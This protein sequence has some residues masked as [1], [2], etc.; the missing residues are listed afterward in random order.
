MSPREIYYFMGKCLV[1]DELPHLRQQILDQI[2]K[3]EFSWEQFVQVGSSHLVLPALYIKLRNANLLS[4]LP[5]ELAS[6]LGEIHALNVER[7]KRLLD[8]I[9]CL[10]QLLRQSGI[11]AV[12]LKGSGVLLSGLYNDPGERILSDIDCLVAESD[13]ER[14]VRGVIAEGYTHPPFL[15]EKL[16]LMHHFPSLFKANEAAQIE[17]H[18]IPVGVRQMK[19]LNLETLNSRLWQ[20]EGPDGPR[21]LSGGDQILINLIHSQL[22]DRGQCYAHIPLRTIYEFY[23]LTRNDDLSDLG[24]LH[25]RIKIILNNY[26]AVAQKLFTPSQPFP[27]K[28]RLRSKLFMFR[29]ELNKTSRIYKRFSKLFRSLADLLFAYVYTLTR[30]MIQKEYRTYL[31]IRLSNPAWYRH[32][33]SVVRKRF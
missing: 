28:N 29:F 7:N 3:P 11:R 5:E 16:P 10:D 30:A 15:P 19:Y 4:S 13:F 33:L 17:I 2:R 18:K 31:R 14:T 21:I 20:A 27:V 23:R 8:Q 24:N 6:Y 22:K 1:L 26:M 9:R 25:P 12:F 32:H